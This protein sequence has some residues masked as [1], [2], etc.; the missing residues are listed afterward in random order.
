MRKSSY[1][2]TLIEVSIFLAVTGI[3]FVAVTVGVQ[4]S[5]YQQRYNDTVNGFADFL[6]NLYSEVLN[7]QSTGNGRHTEAVY[8]K[9]VTF[10]ENRNSNEQSDG[11][12]VIHTYDVLAEAANSWNIGNEDTLTLM[13]K[14]RANVVRRTEEN[15]YELVGVIEDYSPRWSARIQAVDS[16]EDFVGA[17]LVVRNAKSGTIQTFVMEGETIGVREMVSDL[18]KSNINVFEYDDS[19][20]YLYGEGKRFVAR[21]VDFCVNPD[22]EGASSRRADVRLVAGARDA[23]GVEIISF[24]SAA[25]KC[26]NE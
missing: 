24:D 9:L 20:N 23:S 15:N 18:L 14:L 10:G 1:G 6:G 26:R 8:G 13:Y 22:G 2:F 3:L 11:K 21:A 12:Q 19:K 25:N 17:L 7:V 16:F 4:N 5:I